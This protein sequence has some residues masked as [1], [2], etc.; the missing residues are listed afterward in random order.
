VIFETWRA[1]P[2]LHPLIVHFPVVLIPLAV[3]LLAAAF[4][5]RSRALE[6]A[7]AFCMLAGWA[8][9]LTAGQVFHPHSEGMTLVAQGVLDVHET[10]AKWTVGFSAPAALIIAWHSLV[11][12]R[13]PQMALGILALTLSL[14]AAGAVLMAGH[15][16]ATLTHI[17]HVGVE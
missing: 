7:A 15:Q 14:A 5:A 17:H 9:S 11:A 4:L 13:R 2:S 16:G 12:G 8:T 10:W 3:G 6:W 1:F